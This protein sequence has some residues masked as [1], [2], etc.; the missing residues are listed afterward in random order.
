MSNTLRRSDKCRGFSHHPCLRLSPKGATVV[1]IPNEYLP[2]KRGDAIREN[3]ADET[4]VVNR[5][6]PPLRENTE[7]TGFS[8]FALHPATAAIHIL[9]M[10]VIC[11]SSRYRDFISCVSCLRQALLLLL[12]VLNLLL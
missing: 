2:L 8:S 9:L 4:D 11:L 3:E 12:L 10:A 6:P 7:A 1:K 5:A